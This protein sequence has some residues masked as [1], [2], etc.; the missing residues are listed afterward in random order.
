MST[1]GYL[2]A[3]RDLIGDPARHRA[4][5]LAADEDGRQVS[6]LGPAAGYCLAGALMHVTGR[7]DWQNADGQLGTGRGLAATLIFRARSMFPEFHGAP[8]PLG[9]I[10]NALGHGAVMDLLGACV[11]EVWEPDMQAACPA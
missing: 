1:C 10:N 4:G 7:I 6:P 11:A 3:V 8:D 9:G 2:T 5:I